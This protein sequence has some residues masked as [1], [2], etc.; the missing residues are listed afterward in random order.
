M[1]ERMGVFPRFTGGLFDMFLPGDAFNPNAPSMGQGFRTSDWGRFLGDRD[2]GAGV[3]IGADILSSGIPIIGPI[4]SRSGAAGNWAEEFIDSLLN[5][6]KQNATPTFDG[7][8]PYGPYSGN[9]PL[10]P[11]TEGAGNVGGALGIP[12]YSAPIV[13]FP[14]AS[15]D[16]A[17]ADFV[18]SIYGGG[19]G[20]AGGGGGGSW[21]GG[22]FGTGGSGSYSGGTGAGAGGAA[23]KFASKYYFDIE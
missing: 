8:S 4:L 14:Q 10:P 15:A 16:A 13:P 12:D 5:R 20:G 19:G 1:A 6:N 22:G 3:G 18:S 21:G 7:F 2:L 23:S 17:A 9:Y 11:A